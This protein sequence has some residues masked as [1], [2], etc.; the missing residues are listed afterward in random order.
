MQEDRGSWHSGAQYRVPM[1][2]GGIHPAADAWAEKA[3]WKK[4]HWNSLQNSYCCFYRVLL[5]KAV[6]IHRVLGPALKNVLPDSVRIT[7]LTL[8]MVCIHVGN[9]KSKTPPKEGYF[10]KWL[11]CVWTKFKNS[12]KNMKHSAHNIYSIW[13]SI[14]NVRRG[15]RDISMYCFCRGTEF[16]SKHLQGESSQLPLNPAAGDPQVSALICTYPYPYP[17]PCSYTCACTHMYIHTHRNT[18]AHKHM[19]HAHTQIK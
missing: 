2:W 8:C 16:N 15:W 10:Q 12:Y 14:K 7:N 3:Y 17:P 18:Q 5:I 11:D 13:L 6:R 19:H 4:G 1:T 9:H